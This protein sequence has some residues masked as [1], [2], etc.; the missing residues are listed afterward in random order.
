[1]YKINKDGRIVFMC[2]QDIVTG[3]SIINMD[4]LNKIVEDANRYHEMKKSI[5]G[6]LNFE[7]GWIYSDGDGNKEWDT[8]IDFSIDESSKHYREVCSSTEFD[9]V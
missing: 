3:D 5:G 9:E 4:L 8:A 2:G 6:S 7:D 1:M